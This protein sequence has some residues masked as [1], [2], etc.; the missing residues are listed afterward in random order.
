V[1]RS[2]GLET[3][4][5]EINAID[6][7]VGIIADARNRVLVGQ[8]PEGK[9][10]AGEWEFP[11]GKVRSGEFPLHAL[12]RE[13]GEE[14][15]IVVSEAEPFLRQSHRYPELQ[16][17]L[18]VWWV[19]EF[20]GQAKPLENQALRWVAAAELDRFPLLPADAPIVTAIRKRLLGQA[21]D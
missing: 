20:E 10:M 14:L 16:V 6:V 15:G 13:L 8:R 19:L 18:D 4:P 7:V 17:H 3:D 5:P 1:P 12:R 9:P 2:A 21:S 11:G